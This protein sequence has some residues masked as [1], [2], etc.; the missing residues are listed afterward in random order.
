MSVSN[1]AEVAESPFELVVEMFRVPVGDVD[2]VAEVEV[3]ATC[4][5]IGEMPVEVD[6]AGRGGDARVRGGEFFA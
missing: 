2:N 3:M 1:A 5:K 6:P 4:E